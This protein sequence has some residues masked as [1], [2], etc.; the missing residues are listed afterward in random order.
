MVEDDQPLGHIVDDGI[1]EYRPAGE[2]FFAAGKVG[3]IE[4]CRDRVAIG[5]LRFVNPNTA[6]VGE[7]MDE[8]AAGLPMRRQPFAYPAAGILGVFDVL[9]A[10]GGDANQRLE[11]HA[12]DKHML[13]HGKEIAIFPVPQD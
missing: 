8:F 9:A 11:F 5:C 10:A 3:A 12:G 2:L 6:A 13:D 1:L 7:M 4:I